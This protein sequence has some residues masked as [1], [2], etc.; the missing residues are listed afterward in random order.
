MMQHLLE[1]LTVL[2]LALETWCWLRSSGQP[3]DVGKEG[4]EHG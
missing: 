3:A 2:L 1:L 4:E